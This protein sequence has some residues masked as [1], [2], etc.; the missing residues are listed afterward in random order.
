ML[1]P[2][3]GFCH[4]ALGV[5]LHSQGRLLESIA[6]YRRA[7]E[8][9]SDFADT[10]YLMGTA[11]DETGERAEAISCYQQ[12]LALCP[13]FPEALGELGAIFV[14]SGEI[15]RGAA[16]LSRALA[17]QP[18]NAIVQINISSALRLQ[19]KVT[20]VFEG[21]RHALRLAP[22]SVDA[23]AGLAGLLEKTEGGLLRQGNLSNVL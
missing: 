22:D 21:Y 9:Q 16:L 1:N 23:I 13:D 17:L 18:G 20:E 8:L 2:R 4:H 6:A 11:L 10:H 15:E 7:I 19:G 5:A 14:V 3:L 12:A